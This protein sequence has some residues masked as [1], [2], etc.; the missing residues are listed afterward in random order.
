[1]NARQELIRELH[2]KICECKGKFYDYEHE[3]NMLDIM[4]LADFILED[5]KRTVEPLSKIDMSKY[6]NAPFE[7][8]RKTLKN[9]GIE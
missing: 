8:I 7:A 4:K 3:F 5:R 2:D 1:M 6:D 9:A